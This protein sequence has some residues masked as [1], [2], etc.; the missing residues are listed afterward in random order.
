M[1][2]KELKRKLAA[3]LSA[4]VVGY[5]RLMGRDEAGTVHRLTAYKQVLSEV[6][7]KHHGRVVD[8]PGDNLLAEFGSVVNAVQSAITIQSAIQTKNEKLQKKQQMTFRIGINLG[9]VIIDGDRIYGDGVNVAARMESLAEAGGICISGSAYDQI[10]NKF[11]FGCTF[12]GERKVKNIDRPV[13]VYRIESDGTG[14]HCQ[15]GARK[16]GFPKSLIAGGAISILLLLGAAFLLWVDAHRPLGFKA[17]DSPIDQVITAASR[18]AS[19]AVLPLKN[20]SG[21]PE[22]EYF[23]DGI[24]ND[25]I[26]DLSRFGDLL[27]IASNTVF[28]YKGKAITLVEVGRELGVRYILEGSVQKTTD[29]VRINVQLI[30]AASSNHIWAERYTR[31]LK[32]IFK[33]QDDIVQAI[34]GNLTLSITTAER[35]RVLNKKSENLEA[36]DYVLKGYGLFYSRTREGTN[37]AAEMFSKAIE[38]DPRYTAA[39]VGMGRVYERKVGQGWSEFPE[40]SLQRAEALARK[41]LELNQ[42]DAS[43]H[44]LLGAVYAFQGQYGLAVGA[45]Q[46]AIAL[47]PNH[48]RSYHT[49][50]WVLLWS[51]RVDEAVTAL[52]MSLR[53]DGSSPRNT[54]SLLGTAYYLQGRYEAARLVLEKGI[55]KQP[56]YIGNY[57]VLSATYARMG[58]N[59]EA[60]QAAANVRRFDPFFET[61]SYGTG[62]TNKRDRDEIIAGL[63]KAGL[64]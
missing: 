3:I 9:D 2:P 63:R 12:L 64:K 10:E 32:D 14:N 46:R 38:L 48:A 51:G 19:I 23:N 37:K 45:L 4:D 5:S 54:W 61:A 35:H 40:Q 58:H 1:P 57:V 21:D 15:M 34:V 56:D 20:L 39:Y 43:A 27:V 29:S 24:T 11:K 53:L 59:E 47:N 49:L 25:I 18:K 30:D 62:F 17:D 60:S 8:A 44:G 28:S 26:T 13:P 41:A 16:S 7:Q 52:E 22:Q 31:G 42:F 50:G 36:Y 6:I 33:L 55:V